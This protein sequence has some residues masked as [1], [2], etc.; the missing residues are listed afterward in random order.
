MVLFIFLYTSF[1]LYLFI[2]WNYK[3]NELKKRHLPADL[4]VSVLIPMRNES[5]LIEKV[6]NCISQQTYQNFELIIIDD[7]SADDSVQKAK[8]FLK[9][10][11]FLF[12]II[13]LE[14]MYDA[15]YN[16]SNNKKRAIT[17]GVN[18]ASGDLIISIDADITMS[19]HW[20]ASMVAY[21]N[22]NEIVF[23]SA[24]VLY[25][26]QSSFF[27]KFL[28]VDQINNI[29]VTIASLNWGKPIMANGAN[30][31][32]SK[33]AWNAVNGYAGILHV[34]SGDDMMLLH[35]MQ[36]KFPNSIGFNNHEEAVVYT[37]PVKNINEFINQRVR[38]FGKVFH[39]ED[40]TSV[41]FL[42]FGLML[43]LFIVIQLLKLPFFTFSAIIVLFI[44]SFADTIFIT[45]PLYY[46]KRPSYI[47][48]LPLFSILFSIYIV[49]IAIITPF[50][51]YQWKK[52]H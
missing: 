43:N 9:D 8:I 45:A 30:M 38:W 32:F 26:K 21:Y 13:K 46:F 14:D 44:K 31:A 11:K 7:F 39:F 35:R 36:S 22:T 37:I 40:K 15:T 16:T 3:K 52:L 19:E 18:S 1:V 41:V 12:K 48:L 51:K 42:G 25:N 49:G 20:L 2:G 10:S 34:P 27:G 50:Y 29:A 4:L 47:P 33:A 24:P 28:E 6:L 5:E 23:F 17:A